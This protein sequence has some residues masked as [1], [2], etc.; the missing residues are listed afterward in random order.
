[1][2]DEMI[3]GALSSINPIKSTQIG[4]LSTFAS[5]FLVI[6]VATIIFIL[7]L[8]VIWIYFVKN[9]YWINIKVY[10]NI[11]NTPTQVATY[12]AKETTLGFAGDKLWRVAPNSPIS[13]AFKVIKWLPVGK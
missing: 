8:I 2:A 3:G 4:S 10:R 6:A 11:G 13:M 12:K 7:V 9:Q 5:I 1:M